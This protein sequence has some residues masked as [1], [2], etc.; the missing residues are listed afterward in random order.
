MPY[1][2]PLTQKNIDKKY[3]EACL[4]PEKALRDTLCGRYRDALNEAW[5]VTDFHKPDD[6]LSEMDIILTALPIHALNEAVKISN[7]EGFEQ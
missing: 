7:K 1:P 3:K 6:E 5:D 4:S 2:K